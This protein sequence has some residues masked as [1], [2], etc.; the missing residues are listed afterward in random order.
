MSI[1]DRSPP[2]LFRCQECGEYLVKRSTFLKF[3]SQDDLESVNKDL[4]EG[5]VGAVIKFEECCPK[6]EPFEGSSHGTIR[7]LW[8][9]E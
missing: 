4:K 3:L 6:C 7:M 8:P 5:A 9:K 2:F 1:R